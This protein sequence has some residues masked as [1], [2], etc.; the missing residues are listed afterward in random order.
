M[1]KYQQL[2]QLNNLREKGAI[3]QEE[4]EREKQKIL[5]GPDTVAATPAAFNEKQY[6]SF[7]HF[8]QLAGLIIPFAGLILPIVLWVSKKDQS[9]AV[10]QHGKIVINWIISVFIYAIACAIL[11]FIIIG[12]PM[13]IALVIADLVF[14]IIGGIRAAEG[15]YYR[16]PMSMTFL[17]VDAY[18]DPETAY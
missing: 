17:K 7:I 6:C 8:G 9:Y 13:L 4:Y 2:D 14:S 3:T 15:R 1:T 12:I 16:Y 18:D 11:S 10:D 5:N